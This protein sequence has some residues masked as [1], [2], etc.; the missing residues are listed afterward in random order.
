MNRINSLT[1]LKI[2]SLLGIFYWH[3]NLPKNNIDFG[4]RLC[5][6]FFVV[7]GFLVALNFN[8]K[9]TDYSFK[10][11]VSYFK[12]KLKNMYPLHII[13][14]LICVFFIKKFDLI[15]VLFN[16]LLIQS[17]ASDINIYLGYN[18]VSWFLS[19][20][21]FCYFFA[22]FFAHHFKKS[23]LKQNAIIL[24]GL[25]I[26][27]VFLDGLPYLTQY[28]LW[29]INV[30]VNPFVRLFEFLIGMLTF[31]FFNSAKN[32]KNLENKNCNYLITAWEIF[33]FISLALIWKYT[34]FIRAFYIPLIAILIFTMA[35]EKG[36]ISKLLSS[37]IFLFLGSF[38]FEFFM[39]HQLIIKL[40]S[41]YL[42]E[43]RLTP[44]LYLY[45]TIILFVAILTAY[46]YK[47]LYL[48]IKKEN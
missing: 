23:S 11:M 26:F 14:F 24:F 32:S 17:W 38:E 48:K 9:N 20:I 36:Y 43:N 30:H 2:I 42:P 8:T 31:H 22:P 27:R 3:S 45:N 15:I 35:L 1:G 13:T 28:K 40:F 19:S 5:E 41:I 29:D 46:I 25:I 34:S 18:E 44:N 7:S 37:K 16:L 47:N 4:A 21:L 10:N 39:F 6:I 12:R 33:Y